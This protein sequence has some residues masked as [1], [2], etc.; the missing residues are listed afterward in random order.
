VTFALCLLVW[1]LVVWII[2]QGL[3]ARKMEQHLGR[4]LAEARRR[5]ERL[6]TEKQE[7]EGRCMRLFHM[8]NR[9]R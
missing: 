4:E 8:G 3:S 1:A 9:P 2:L 7:L 6:T 5:I